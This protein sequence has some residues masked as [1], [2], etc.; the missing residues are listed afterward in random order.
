MINDCEMKSESHVSECVVV[1]LGVISLDLGLGFCQMARES[2]LSV[3]ARHFSNL[4]PYVLNRWGRLFKA[5]VAKKLSPN[6]VTYYFVPWSFGSH[7]GFSSNLIFH[8]RTPNADTYGGQLLK[9]V[10]LL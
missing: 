7:S 9:H 6:L 4:R 5:Q 10:F 2:V 8:I 1:D 3:K